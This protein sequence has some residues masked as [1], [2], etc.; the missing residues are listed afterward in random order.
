MPLH[1]DGLRED[2]ELLF[3]LT[4]NRPHQLEA[5][6]EEMLFSGGSLNVKLLGGAAAE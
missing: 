1:V 3:V 5:A 4:T 2:A 6:L